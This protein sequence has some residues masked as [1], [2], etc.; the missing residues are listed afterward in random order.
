M[1]P[2]KTRQNMKLSG[3]D[4]RLIAKIRGF[5]KLLISL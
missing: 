3:L 4:E 2:A 5:G 1:K